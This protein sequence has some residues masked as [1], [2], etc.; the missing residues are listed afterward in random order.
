MNDLRKE[1]PQLNPDFPKPEGSQFEHP[2]Q[3]S[4]REQ[5]NF[6]QAGSLEAKTQQVD[7]NVNAGLEAKTKQEA[8]PQPTDVL[9][10]TEASADQKQLLNDILN[11]NA[12][13]VVNGGR[14][15]DN[16]EAIQEMVNEA[17]EDE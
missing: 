13:R 2:E 9:L 10:P 17:T 6:D 12:N 7:S 3:V 8:A 5:E 14:I 15:S 11:G 4:G 16:A 1:H